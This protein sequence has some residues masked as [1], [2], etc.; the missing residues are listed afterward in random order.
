MIRKVHIIFALI[1][2]AGLSAALS[3]NEP[4]PAP[5]AAPTTDTTTRGIDL[6]AQIEKRFKETQTYFGEFDQL[7]VSK[8]MLEEIPSKGRFWYEK[9]GKFRCEYL[10]PNEQVNLIVQDTAWVHIPQIKQVEVYH[11]RT[12][13]SPVKK[14][15]HMLLGFGASVKDVLEVYDVRWIPEEEKPDVFALLFKPKKKEEGLSFQAITIWMKKESLTPKRLVFLEDDED[16]TE[17]T[18][19]NIKFNEKI[20]E[21]VFKPDFPRDAEVIERN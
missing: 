17:I 12:E 15:N 20:K 6:L 10:P 4:T 9:P 2:L 13:D 11:F 1:M 3:A 8:L 18:L 19:T 7:K 14:L 21:S 16:T 5:T